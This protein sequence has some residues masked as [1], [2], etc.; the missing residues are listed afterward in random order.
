MTRRA[1]A[2]A[3]LL[4]ALV[5]LV[6]VDVRPPAATAAVDDEQDP[7]TDSAMTVH[8]LP[9]EFGDDFTGLTITVAQTK[10]LT[11]QGVVVSWTGGKPS[12]RRGDDPAATNYLQLM[13]C[14]GPDPAA[15]D[16]RETCQVGGSSV[17]ARAPSAM[18]PRCSDEVGKPCESLPM[19]A[20]MV[21]FRP[22]EGKPTPHGG[23]AQ[24][25]PRK[26]CG[27]PELKVTC[28]STEA[29]VLADYYS[30]YTTNEIPKAVTAADG[31]GR[32]VFEMQTDVE[33]PHLG[34][35][36]PGH[37][38]CWLVIV[39][40]GDHDRSKN[41]T[42]QIEGSPLGARVFQDAIPV[43]LQ[44]QPV[45]AFCSLER[46]ERRTTGTE[47]VAGAML[48]WQ[49]ALCENDGP[50]F[51]YSTAADDN[52][53]RQ[54]LAPDGPGL[55]F[56]SDPVVSPPDGPRLVHAP[57]ALSAVVIAFNIDFR[58]D[59][60]TTDS[61]AGRMLR[62]V[63]LTPRLVAKL[64]TQS[65]KRDI[66]GSNQQVYEYLQDNPR[67]L[68]LD[69][70]FIEA[71]PQFD[72]FTAIATFDG[73]MVPI[74][75]S[76]I[77]REVWRWILADPDARAW[78]EG[79]PDEH[80]MVVNKEYLPLFATGSAPT[81]F[82]REDL[83]CDTPPK[84]D[85]YCALDLRPYQGSFAEAGYQ[86]L[87]ADAKNRTSWDPN[88]F[89]KAAYKAFPP[90]QVTQRFAASIT[91]AATAAR[92]GLFTARLR[93]RA[94]EFVAPT[95]QSVLAAAAAT[96]PSGTAGVREIDP[97]ASI[98]GAYPLG[99]V[100][101]AVGDTTEE[102][103]ARRD[104]ANLIR[105]AVGTGQNPGVQRGQLP[106]GY[107]PLPDGLRAEARAAA[108]AL[109]KAKPIVSPTPTPPESGGTGSPGESAGPGS[110]PES[111]VPADGAPPVAA[112]ATPVAPALPSSTPVAALTQ[113]QPLGSI[114]YALLGALGLGAVAA[115]AG[116][117]VRRI[118]RRR[119]GGRS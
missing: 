29:D 92:Y 31:T 82:P 37:L 5:G 65:Y 30:V 79:K 17:P 6:T 57:V 119:A 98:P 104:Y 56:T 8:G 77:A 72:G 68:R 112:P 1:L 115:L 97:K 71:N 81:N 12:V 67:T 89:P 41:P 114:R 117:A 47:L 111:A 11:S 88:A 60:G 55:V 40:R 18:D 84:Q 70:E 66:P 113:G 106:G 53:G 15:P 95:D 100:T 58:V 109:E 33:A 35:G 20:Q 63:N 99:M 101:Y 22:V 10:A 28:P 74:G 103:A 105:Y 75:N 27:P 38:T 62:E 54:V 61:R 9:G 93:N 39:P 50:V 78:L 21:P 13:Q 23:A 44:F 51:G 86:T 69:P 43:P 94:G 16:F 14:W 36:S 96:V 52:A 42:E 91:D 107:V 102:Q 48:S 7:V 108:E 118:G 34:C 110:T 24:P 116:P 73:L 26:A 76:A 19:D 45:G 83:N 32:V 80:G 46:A 59:P 87:R 64:L 3:V 2:L 85:K 4:F 90:Q 49:P 25:W